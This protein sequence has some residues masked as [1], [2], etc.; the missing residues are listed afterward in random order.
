[1]RPGQE[2]LKLSLT[3][4]LQ[5]EEVIIHLSILDTELGQIPIVNTSST[6]TSLGKLVKRRKEMPNIM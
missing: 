3:L 5:E 2:L 4:Q 1:M 6:L